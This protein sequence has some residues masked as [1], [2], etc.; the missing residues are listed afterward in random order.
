MDMPLSAE[1]LT[2][3]TAFQWELKSPNSDGST[4]N[5]PLLLVLEPTTR[6]NFHCVHCSRTFAKQA[7]SD[8]SLELFESVVEAARTAYELYLF[9]DGEVLLDVP[10]HLAMIS[11]IY[12]RD[13]RC[14]LGFSTNG[15]LLTPEVYELY[16]MA[17][18]EY[19]QLS[20]DAASQGLYE[21]IRR[22]GDF[23]RL[24]RNLDGIAAFRRRSKMR[25]PQLYLATVNS[26]QNYRELPLLAKLA[27]EY[28]FAYW[29]INVEYPH[30]PGRDALR[31]T[32]EDLAEVE[33][34]KGD[35]TRDYGLRYVT[36]FDASI[37]LRADGNEQLPTMDAPVY[38]TV[39]WQRFELKA[40]GDVKIC[41]YFHEPV[42]SMN[43]KSL[44]E[45]WNGKE[46]REIRKAF[47][48]GKRIPSYCRKC[49]LSLRRQYLPGWPGLPDVRRDDSR[50]LAVPRTG[51]VET[52]RSG[53]LRIYPGS[54]R[55]GR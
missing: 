52:L 13:P 14:P 54:V 28:D 9:G 40:N 8:M 46:F 16:A 5:A 11:S 50:A 26:R 39:P 4:S 24:L 42:C 10:R 21:T 2:N 22:G 36:V 55:S 27:A 44:A 33:L 23:D 45:V 47:A 30:N 38:C 15:Q 53:W 43:G 12:R 6:C 29:Y 18:I 37:G 19:I 3:L 17:G 51:A 34:M 48:S 7:S 25:H 41:P 35:I 20:V 1:K 49:N 32:A 31:L